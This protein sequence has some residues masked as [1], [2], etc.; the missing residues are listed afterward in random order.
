[1]AGQNMSN[2]SKEHGLQANFNGKEVEAKLPIVL[3][4]EVERRSSWSDYSIY[5]SDAAEKNAAGYPII[6]Q[7]KIQRSYVY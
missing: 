4:S 2:K 1:M 7:K 6:N 3:Q 5:Q